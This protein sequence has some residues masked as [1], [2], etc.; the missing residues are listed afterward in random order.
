MKNGVLTILL[1]S[2]FLVT[3]A[4]ENN[5]VKSSYQLNWRNIQYFENQKSLVFDESTTLDG[6]NL[7][8]FTNTISTQNNQQIDSL[9]I[10]SIVL[11][12][13]TS[14]EKSLIEN[15]SLIIPDSAIIKLSYLSEQKE[16]KAF[17]SFLPII[18]QN[19]VLK[20]IISFDISY[21]LKSQ[22]TFRSTS[23]ST[24]GLHQYAAHSVLQTGKWVKISV[25]QTGIYKIT[26]SDLVKWGIPNPANAHIFGYGGAKL[27]EDFRK[28]KLDDLPQIAVWKEKGADG[29][30][31]E[32]DY[33][34]FYAQGPVSWNYDSGNSVF[35]RTIN[36]YSF[37]GYYFIS[38]D[39]GVEKIITTQPSIAGTPTI[40][41]TNFLDHQVYEKELINILSS[42]QN[43]YGEEFSST[44]EYT[45]PFSFPNIDASQN[46][47]VTVDAAAKSSQTTHMSAYLNNASLGS[48]LSFSSAGEFDD[49]IKNTSTYSV[50]PSSSTL[51]V[52][53]RY[54]D[55]SIGKAWLNYITINA[56]RN[57]TMTDYAMFFRNPK[58]VQAGQLATY[59]LSGNAG[60]VVWDITK[61]EDIKQ[62]AS[63]Y[64][65]GQYIFADSAVVLKEYVAVNPSGSFLSPTLVSEVVNQDLH[66]LPQTDMVI[67]THPDYISQAQTLAQK[68]RSKDGI[69]VLI[70]TPD[71]IYN[72]F[73]SGTPDATAYRWLMKMFYDRAQSST[74]APKYLLLFGD[75]T[76]DNRLI[77][78]VNVS[79][80][81]L[82]T[83]QASE[84]LNEISSYVSDDYFGLLDDNEGANIPYGLLDIGIGRFPVSTTQQAT[85]VVNKITNY[86]D[87]NQK[88]YWKNRLA[89]IAD[90]DDATLH[91]CQSDTLVR[92]MEKNYPSY[93]PKR[94]FLDSYTQEV[95]A[96]GQ[97]YPLAKEKFFNLLNS[98]IFLVNYTGHGST[99]GLANEKI[100]SRDDIPNM[101]NNMLPLF[102]TASCSFSRFDDTKSSSGEDLFLNAHGG[103]IG[104]FS[105]TRTVYASNN[106]ELNKRF[107]RYIFKIENNKPLALGE[108]MRR[109][110]N[111]QIGDQNRL[112]FTLLADPALLLSLPQNKVIVTDIS[113]NSNVVSDTVKALSTV[114]VKGHIETPQGALLNQFNGELTAAVYDK[115]DSVKTLGNEG[116]PIYTYAD[117]QNILFFGKTSVVNGIFTL[118]FMVPKDIA[119]NYG[120]GRINFYADDTSNNLEA[121]GYDEDFTIGS[122]KSD[123][124]FENQ[125]PLIDM[126]I[127]SPEFKNGQSVDATPVFTANLSDENGINAV[128]SGIGHDLSL[129]LNNDPNL[130]YVLNDY[131]ESS[132]G[133]YRSGK[134]VYEIP[135]LENGSY[136]LTFKAWDLLDNSSTKSLKFNVVTGIQPELYS[137]YA[138]PNPAETY[139]RFI[140]KHD[141]PQSELKIKLYV[142]NLTGE[143]LW[144][145]SQTTY[146]E[147]NNTEIDWDLTTTFGQR[148]AKGLYLYT[149]YVESEEQSKSSI[150]TNKLLVR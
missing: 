13:F 102:V 69:S 138:V 11:G 80:N 3:S 41:V 129:T 33:L 60:L 52:K 58:I 47:T 63:S 32:G 92:Y 109:T 42:G 105:T 95:G 27:P 84:S 43:W 20:K 30:F 113:S 128:G 103:A 14:E 62:M 37:F 146:A 93:Q 38:S 67:I 144:Q 116:L 142:Y 31:N 149:I 100:I 91:T 85:D 29:V 127:N 23:T 82:L 137:F 18:K 101:Y 126:Y 66:A 6:S 74:D 145:T 59:T 10:K 76:Y 98:G 73:S 2:L 87:N 114:T 107:N 24:S 123:F 86:M 64:N 19:G 61:A 97:S 40:S 16:Q 71:Q 133:D 148:L 99:E 88:G 49:G 135:T 121:Q 15:T 110:K 139:V 122:S 90:D 28:S 147:N 118:T 25:D 119:Y 46:A 9:I 17:I 132:L 72:E 125:G 22:P 48:S 124:V 21:C 51:N 36:P 96:S 117:R 79:V 94:F 26:Y 8:Y 111:D 7:P 35:T 104:L 78:S 140:V 54:N 136:T 115:I 65:G 12:D 57:L 130:T 4:S 1:L 77:N 112:N 120:K 70:V 50:I 34:L 143:L 75:G 83:Y 55:T 134:L 81:K 45:I 150:K 108:I 89:Y 141:Q 106:F 56:F 131:Y 53:L 39:V 5:L 44:A 68:H